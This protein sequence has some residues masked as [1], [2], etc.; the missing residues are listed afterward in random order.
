MPKPGKSQPV[1]LATSLS[2]FRTPESH[3]PSAF[4][5]VRWESPGKFCRAGLL[6]LVSLV[7]TL[8]GLARVA[9]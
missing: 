9:P 3:M 7:K 1:S 4:A 8:E 2:A 6:A 5:S